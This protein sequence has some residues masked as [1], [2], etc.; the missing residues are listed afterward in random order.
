MRRA[1]CACG[2]FEEWPIRL[3]PTPATLAGKTFTSLEVVSYFVQ[4]IGRL[5]GRKAITPVPAEQRALTKRERR[6][7]DGGAPK[8]SKG[9]RS[10]SLKPATA[11][12][13]VSTRSTRARDV[14]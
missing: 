5:S 12:L 6:H 13:S 10:A 7:D 3:C 9:E 4:S 11:I 14:A 8:R 2:N 1:V